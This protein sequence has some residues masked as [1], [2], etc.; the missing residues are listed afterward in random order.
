MNNRIAEI[1]KDAGLTQAKFAAQLN[2]SRNFLWMIE[3]GDRVPSDR[4]IL[5]ICREFNVSKEWLIN[6]TGEKYVADADK[7]TNFV[8]SLAG[9]EKNDFKHRMIEL[10]A[11]LT[12][13]EWKLLEKMAQRLTGK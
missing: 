7:I 12:P 6:G 4:T 3:K 2:L 11:D 13:D 10:L 5:D 9:D 1:R 8:G